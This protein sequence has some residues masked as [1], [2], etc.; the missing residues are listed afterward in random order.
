MALAGTAQSP[1]LE[2]AVRHCHPDIF[3]EK[4]YSRNLVR[5]DS[6]PGNGLAG[7]ESRTSS[8]PIVSLGLDSQAVNDAEYS[9]RT[10]KDA[11][12]Y[13]MFV[14]EPTDSSPRTS[15]SPPFADNWAFPPQRSS[16]GGDASP[17][18]RRLPRNRRP[19]SDHRSV[20]RRYADC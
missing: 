18:C 9:V 10:H 1:H 14:S 8:P 5:P 13:P 15:P 19:S 3:F 2:W 11:G 6:T 12:V 16:R 7:S 4:P 17:K 20:A